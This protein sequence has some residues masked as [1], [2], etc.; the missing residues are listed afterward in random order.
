M[1]EP[2]VLLPLERVD[3]VWRSGEDFVGE[4][5]LKRLCGGD[6]EDVS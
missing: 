3:S 4:W 6:E 2:S 5:S 1:E